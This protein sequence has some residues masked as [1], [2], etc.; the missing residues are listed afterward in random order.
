MLAVFAHRTQIL[1]EMMLDQLHSHNAP[2]PLPMRIIFPT[3]L[4]GP[5][6]Y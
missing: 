5:R 4:P 2:A 1:L 3:N 6:E